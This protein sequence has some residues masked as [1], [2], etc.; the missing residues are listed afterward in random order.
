MLSV[1]IKNVLINSAINLVIQPHNNAGIIL[2]CFIT[3]KMLKYNYPHAHSGVKQS[4]L[5]VCHVSQ[6]VSVSV[7]TKI[8]QPIYPFSCPI[9]KAI[10]DSLYR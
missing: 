3:P 7:N 10:T 1:D 5:S 2:K 8:K 9:G 4:V 6:S